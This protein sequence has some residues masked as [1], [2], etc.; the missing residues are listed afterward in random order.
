MQ[1]V[2]IS[3]DGHGEGA[4]CNRLRRGT[5]CGRPSRS[6]QAL[7]RC[8]P[9]ERPSAA[10]AV[11]FGDRSAPLGFEIPGDRRSSGPRRIA[12]RHA[13]KR[14]PKG[15][16]FVR[17][18][19]ADLFRRRLFSARRVR[20]SQRLRGPLPGSETRRPP[21]RSRDDRNLP[22]HDRDGGS[23]LQ[24]RAITTRSHATWAGPASSRLLIGPSKGFHR[25][26]SRFDC[27]LESGISL[28]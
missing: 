6:R 16:R 19:S 27:Q 25:Q 18:G 13:A 7:A 1:A 11:G 8:R 28:T 14:D 9:G 22:A 24:P 10:Q 15:R 5:C 2:R 21:G 17:Q 12:W 23:P 4:G 20:V 26:S 3:A